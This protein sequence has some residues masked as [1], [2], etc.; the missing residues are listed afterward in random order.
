VYTTV[1]LLTVLLILHVTA[2]PVSAVQSA[3]TTAAE[4]VPRVQQ[5]LAWRSPGHNITHTSSA[6]TSADSG[7][8]FAHP[9]SPA[10]AAAGHGVFTTMAAEAAGHR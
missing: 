4:G 5:Q 9:S 8:R 1:T 3:A 6:A 7:T 10:A 2:T